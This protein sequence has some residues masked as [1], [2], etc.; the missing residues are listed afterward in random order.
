[1]HVWHNVLSVALT[2]AMAFALLPRSAARAADEAAAPEKVSFY[3]KIRPILQ[4]RCHGC[5]QPAKPSGEYV[6]TAFEG[7][8]KGGES[9]SAAVVPGKPEES[10]LVQMITPVDGKAE[11]PEGGE[12]LTGTEIA[13]VVQWIREGATDDTPP[14]TEARYDREHPPTYVLPPVITSLD[15][16]PDNS[17]LAVSGY[18]EVLVHRADGSA[19][20]ARLVGL[21]E[22]IESAV[23]SPDGKRLAVTGGRPARMGEVQIWNVQDQALTLSVPVTY[24]TV[25]GASWSPDGKYVAFGCSDNSVRAID[26]DTGQQVLLQR[27]PTDWTLDTVFSKDGS[28]LV[29]VGRD[30]TV[31]LI[32]FQTQRFVDNI[33]SI[34]PGALKGGIHAVDRHPTRDEIVVGGDDGVPRTYRLYRETA[35]RI[36]DDSNLLR[37]FPPLPGRIFGIAVSHD[38]QYMAAGSSY[39]RSGKVHVYA[40]KYDLTVPEEIKK[41]QS[42]TSDGRTTEERAALDKYHESDVEL[43]AEMAGQKGSVYAV[44]FRHDGSV[45]ASGGFEGLVRLNDAKTGALIAEFAP[46][47]LDARPNVAQTSAAQ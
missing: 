32:E 25:Y 13:L 8:L 16:S 2:G 38:G 46:V 39:E 27:S 19:L 26:A 42:K 12:P 3:Q 33:T 45:V 4:A 15:F 7:L 14:G 41:I 18:H 47:P 10:N 21:S 17:L 29:S 40:I 34:T 9:E 35:R 37:R 6:M 23:F 20:V 11:M 22:R 5:H 1:M 31:K 36:G 30:M 43:V 44:A 24:D 28:H